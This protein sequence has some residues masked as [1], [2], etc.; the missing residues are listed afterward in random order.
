MT[1][2]SMAEQI[3]EVIENGSTADLLKLYNFT[4]D[5]NRTINDIND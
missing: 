2:V 3:V 1:T 4:F 5:T